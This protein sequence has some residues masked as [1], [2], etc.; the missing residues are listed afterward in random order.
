MRGGGG[1]YLIITIELTQS[2]LVKI[3]V[4]EIHLRPTESQSMVLKLSH[5]QR[6]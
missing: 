6:F 3:Q 4:P 1:E 5:P 2:Y